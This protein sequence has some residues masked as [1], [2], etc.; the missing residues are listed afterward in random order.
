MGSPWAAPGEEPKSVDHPRDGQAADAGPPMAPPPGYPPPGYGPPG[1]P[2]PGYGPPGYPP[3]GYGPPGYGPPY[4][5]PGYGPAG[6]GPVGY[7]P[8][9]YGPPRAPKPGVIPL[10]PLG[11]GE[12]LDGAVSYI[13]ANPRVTLGVS[14]VVLTVTQLIQLAAQVWFFRD[15]AT[16]DSLP[17]SSSDEAFAQ[18][19]SGGL[20][21]T[22]VGLVLTLIAGTL[23]TGLLIVVVGRAVLGQQVSLRETWDAARPR[24][25]GLVGLSLLL[26]GILLAVFVVLTLPAVAA[27]AAGAPGLGAGLITLGVLA[28][29]VLATYLFVT[30]ALAAPAYMLERV[31]VIDALR[32][33]RHLVRTR[34]WPIFG[35]L[36]L[37][38][39]LAGLIAGII[40]L[41]FSLLGGVAGVALGLEEDPLVVTSAV[42]LTIAAIGAILA[43]TITAPF[44]AG[45][46]G[47]LYFDQRMR[48]EGLDIEL[49]R[50]A[51][52][53]PPGQAW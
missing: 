18:L 46:T 35:I 19:A 48:R 34:W 40:G 1:Y 51:P 27:F 32:R 47:L 5:P 13:R 33:S 7:G 45:V 49:A 26:F 28:G 30:F 38:A 36:L 12:I 22:L 16:L 3:P 41:P 4:P 15:L 17:T 20:V 24:L 53:S 29:I 10:R 52:G 50:S 2:P 42:A 11:L 21:A 9:G 6:Y 39:L 31:G 14:A 25:P 37:A 43:G 44:Q 23:L 8:A